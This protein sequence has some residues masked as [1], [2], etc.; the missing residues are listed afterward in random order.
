MLLLVVKKLTDSIVIMHV[1]V[2]AINKVVL[3][4]IRSNFSGC[5]ALLFHRML[6]RTLRVKN[7]CLVNVGSHNGNGLYGIRFLIVDVI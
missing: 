1:V 2:E 4:V 7:G 6:H 5:G 3:G